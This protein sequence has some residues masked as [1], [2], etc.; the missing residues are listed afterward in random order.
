[1]SFSLSSIHCY[2]CTPMSDNG[3]RFCT[4]ISSLYSIV[5]AI[6]F[7]WIQVS[8]IQVFFAYMTRLKNVHTW[9]VSPQGSLNY[10]HSHT[11]TVKNSTTSIITL[12]VPR[13]C[14]ITCCVLLNYNMLCDIW[15][16]IILF[17][18]NGNC[19]EHFRQLKSCNSILPDVPVDQGLLL[20]P[21][22]FPHDPCSWK[23]QLVIVQKGYETRLASGYNWRWLSR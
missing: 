20:T 13:L 18:W 5:I 17:E 19:R 1:M 11:L 7:N 3:D 22:G 8:Y 21:L 12:G 14:F 6:L 9:K 4:Y 16:S 15:L 2:Y 10:K 23:G